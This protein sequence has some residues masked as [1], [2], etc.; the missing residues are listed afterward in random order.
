MVTIV[1]E[2]G[3]LVTGANSYITA[4]ELVDYAALRGVTL[5]APETPG[6]SPTTPTTSYA[7]AGGTG[8]RASS[9][10]VTSDVDWGD[11]YSGPPGNLSAQD[12]NLVNGSFAAD[13]NGS[14][15]F[16]YTGFVDGSYIQFDFGSKKYIDE[17]RI[18]AV[19]ASSVG[20]WK[21]EAS[22]DA[23][24]WTEQK[25]SF[26]WL[27]GTANVYSFTPTDVLGFR[28]WRM[29]KVTTNGSG[30]NW[31]IE[32]DFKIADGADPVPAII[33]NTAANLL[34]PAMDY[35]EGQVFKGI[36]IRHDQAL[37]WPRANVYIDGYL[38]DYDEIPQTLKDAQ[39]EVALSLYAGSDPLSN[40][41]KNQKRVKVGDLEVEYFGGRS[42]PI[43]R[44]ILN[45]LWKLLAGGVSGS[46]FTV[47]RG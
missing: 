21:I 38:V 42:E 19:G 40:L 6:P 13:V 8:N 18:S 44:K 12:E 23:N 5:P 43:R 34:I 36:K 17:F 30:G 28:Y 29:T 11:G 22:N 10:V 31:C 26:E 2:D 15:L 33:D 16:P 27:R 46:S 9:I 7:N 45:K 32:F 4:Q 14:I 41:A 24:T 47:K 25:A 20:N 39:A 35:I 3:T 37:Q 1:I